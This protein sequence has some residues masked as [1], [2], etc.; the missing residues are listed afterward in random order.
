MSVV[1]PQEV[2][3]A[4]RN[5]C[6]LAYDAVA[7]F[8]TGVGDGTISEG[9]ATAM[10]TAVHFNGMTAPECYDWTTTAEIRNSRRR[11]RKHTPNDVRPA[12]FGRS[13]RRALLPTVP[14]CH[15]P[16]LPKPWISTTTH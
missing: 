5:G 15:R 10:A 4:E 13:W 12:T 16:G 1:L 14:G 2:N 6:I 11:T 8:V 7:A 9:Q 3:Q